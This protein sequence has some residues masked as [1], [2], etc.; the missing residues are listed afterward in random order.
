MTRCLRIALI[1]AC[2]VVAVGNNAYAEKAGSVGVRF[3][4]GT[5]INGGIAYGGQLNYTLYQNLNAVEMGLA[6]FGGKFEEDSNNG[7]NNYHEETSIFVIGAIVNYLFRYSLDV[8]GPYLLAGIGVG[9]ISV[10]WE[11]SSD[12]DSSLGTPLPG[13]GS[14]Q[15]EEGSVAGLIL[16]FGIGHRFNKT[17]D[18]RAQVPTFFISETENRDGKV[19][20]MITITAGLS[21]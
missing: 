4:I 9:T 2:L 3:G 21:F 6:V 7:F 19:V 18:L 16:N 13:G 15:S 11:E 1:L 8:S 17:F 14:M 20:P 12:T 5:D 10:E